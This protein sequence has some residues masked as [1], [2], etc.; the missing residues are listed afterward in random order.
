MSLTR[1]DWLKSTVGTPALLAL[2]PMVP[3]ILSRAALA[4]A[5]A[6]TAATTFWSSCSCPAGTTA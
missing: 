1:R 3:P 2:A 5:A 6:P 4:A